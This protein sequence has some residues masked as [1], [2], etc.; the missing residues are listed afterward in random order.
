MTGTLSSGVSGKGLVLAIHSIA[1]WCITTSAAF[2]WSEYTV[3]Q[4]VPLT[5]YHTSVLLNY[6]LCSTDINDC[7]P[8]P[9]YG[10]GNCT[11]LLGAYSCNCRPGF[12]GPRCQ[13]GRIEC[14]LI[15]HAENSQG[16]NARGLNAGGMSLIQFFR[17]QWWC[18]TC[19]GYHW[20][21]TK[22]PDGSCS[23]P[24]ITAYSKLSK[25]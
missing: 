17:L 19:V 20:Y 16:A 10:H 24:F 13:H 7:L 2:D 12:R 9:C 18:T 23:Q 8:D 14:P 15:T 4:N 22:R 21:N 1:A 3:L 5:V 6:L 11:D 25:Y